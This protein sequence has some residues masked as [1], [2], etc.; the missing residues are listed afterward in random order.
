M[1]NNKNYNYFYDTEIY[2]GNYFLLKFIPLNVDESRTGDTLKQIL[3]KML[4]Y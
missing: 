1:T 2:L 4:T 3:L